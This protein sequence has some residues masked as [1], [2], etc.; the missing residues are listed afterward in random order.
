MME[1]GAE[2]RERGFAT[3]LGDSTIIVKLKY[4]RSIYVLS[5]CIRGL[6]QC[7]FRAV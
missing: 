7:D 5:S 1:H 2:D 6:R 3:L 4:G